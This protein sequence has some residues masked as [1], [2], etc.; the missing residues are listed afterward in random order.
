MKFLI[1][2]KKENHKLKLKIFHE[3]LIV[4]NANIYLFNIK[5]IKK[6]LI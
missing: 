2:E 6:N 5:F 1:L 4:V 3:N